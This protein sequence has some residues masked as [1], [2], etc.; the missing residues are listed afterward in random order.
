MS[1][2]SSWPS[3]CS[4]AG[5]RNSQASS[6]LAGALFLSAQT[7][8]TEDFGTGAT[9]TLVSNQRPPA[10]PFNSITLND[11]IT[12]NG[13]TSTVDGGPCPGGISNFTLNLQSVKF[14]TNAGSSGKIIVSGSACGDTIPSTTI[15]L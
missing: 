12:T 8:L 15:T 7:K 2:L 3:G 13:P 10:N 14:D 5:K 4:G 1:S 9:V 6:V 11:D